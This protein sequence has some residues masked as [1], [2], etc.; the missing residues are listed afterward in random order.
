VSDLSDAHFI[1]NGSKFLSH[2]R[3]TIVEIS[4]ISTK[5]Q[6]SFWNGPITRAQFNRL[7]QE[8]SDNRSETN[9]SF[10]RVSD[11]MSTAF[12]RIDSLERQNARLIE[13]LS[14]LEGPRPQ[15]AAVRRPPTCAICGKTG[16][17]S[18]NSKFHP[19]LIPVVRA[20]GPVTPPTPVIM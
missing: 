18:N 7:R 14:E 1:Y 9:M 13:R 11:D 8:V 20:T 5:T 3:A 19:L 10:A 15:T 12:A 6:M 17:Y 16:H 2:F 4:G